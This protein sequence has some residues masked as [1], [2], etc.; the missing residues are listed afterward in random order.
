MRLNDSKEKNEFTRQELRQIQFDTIDEIIAFLEENNVVNETE[1]FDH[2]IFGKILRHK[3]SGQTAALILDGK[4]KLSD[5]AIER[6]IV[7][8]WRRNFPRPGASGE[9]F[10]ENGLIEFEDDDEI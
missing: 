10:T 5:M 8:E 4:Y 6:L 7:G 2:P 9:V 1:T 3:N